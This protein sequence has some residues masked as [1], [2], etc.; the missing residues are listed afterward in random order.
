MQ[1]LQA[2]GSAVE[3]LLAKEGVASSNLVSRS[4]KETSVRRPLASGAPQA[5]SGAPRL[6]PD[7]SSLRAGSFRSVAT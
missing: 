3:R 1:C 2:A 6:T 4:S 5:E 7:A